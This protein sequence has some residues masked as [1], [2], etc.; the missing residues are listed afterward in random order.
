MN[1]VSLFLMTQKGFGVLQSIRDQGMTSL[2]DVVVV[3]R[4]KNTLED[5]AEEIIELCEKAK[6][7]WVERT[8]AYTI[9]ST[10]AIAIS[11]RWLLNIPQEQSQLIIFHDSLL[12]KYRGF[13]PLVNQLIQGER[14]IGASALFA[15]QTYDTG[16]IIDQEKVEISYPLTIK[17]AISHVSI[18]YQT[19]IHR[20]LIQIKEGKTLHSTS[21]IES[22]A[23]YS[24]WR[25]EEDYQID[26]TQDA[27]KIK[28]FIDAVG[29]PYKGASS[30]IGDTKVRILEAET[31]EDVEV[32]NRDCGK[33]IFMRDK[34][35]VVVCGKG[36]LKITNGHY[37]ESKR[38]LL[39]M[40]KFRIR[41]T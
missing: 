39:P 20:I 27:E 16:D 34:K 26:W 22:E 11:W 6:I 2:I 40:K 19:L 18:A 23:T 36:L 38:P 25:N 9:S 7:K 15:D 32:V 17:Q 4:D 21:Q 1:K 3:G 37:E 14:T 24:L 41:F 28:R 8:D 30:W 12:P 13:A 33:V 5:S 31:E 35:P 10:Y 29:F